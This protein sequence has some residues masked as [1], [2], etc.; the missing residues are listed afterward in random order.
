MTKIGFKDRFNN[1]GCFLKTNIK[2]VILILTLSILSFGMIVL[3]MHEL[4]VSV[5][6]K[7]ALLV[8]GVMIFL[9]ILICIILYFAKK[10]RWKIDRIFLICGILLGTF[11][12]FSIPPGAI[13][14][15]PAHFARAYEISEGYIIHPEG[16]IDMPANMYEIISS[17]YSFNNDSYNAVLNNVLIHGDSEQ[18]EFS[19]PDY[20]VFNYMP[21]VIGIKIAKILDLPLIP[22]MWVGRLFNM[23]FCV[24]IIALCIKYIPFLKKALFLIALFP[25]TMHLFSSVSADGAIICAGIALI[26]YVFY[27]KKGMKRKINFWDLLLLLLIC[28]TLV[29]TKP[30][31]AFLCPIVLWIPKDRFKSMKQKIIFVIILG[32]LT[33]L[34][35]MIL[36]M[37]TSFAMTGRYG[38]TSTQTDFILHN[39]LV[40]LGLVFRNMV[41]SLYDYTNQIIGRGLE[42]FTVDIYAPYNM[43]LFILFI[44]LCAERESTVKLN[45]RIF[46][47][48]SF[49][50]TFFLII[51]SMFIIWSMPGSRDIEGVQGRYLLPVLLL[52][53]VLCLPSSRKDKGKQIVSLRTLYI[54]TLLIN[55]YVVAT[56]MV[57]HIGY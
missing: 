57:N 25:M 23:I 38:P 45:L 22:M 26:T 40:Y 20:A 28:L 56:I 8:F 17:D 52:I 18:R 55:V 46:S 16:G 24:T 33:C 7:R 51:T 21:Q 6:S 14:D 10:K 30:V 34:V 5:F 36:R 49:I 19:Y 2:S 11:Y 47:F 31:Y 43:I 35:M 50:I 12:C 32:F 9:T 44:L 39:P 1:F 42:W 53:P 4:S 41:F 29:M 54:T 3:K 13:P 15:E 27:A 48:V 37:L